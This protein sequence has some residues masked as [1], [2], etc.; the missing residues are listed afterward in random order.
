MKKVILFI[1]C[2]LLMGCAEPMSRQE[3]IAA[4]KE[5]QDGNMSSVIVHSNLTGRQV[6]VR[7]LLAKS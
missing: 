7:C 3:V 5:C 2:L 6:E 1:V 4:V